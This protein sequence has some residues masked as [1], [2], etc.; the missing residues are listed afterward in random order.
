MATKRVCDHC[1]AEYFA[2]TGKLAGVV[3][4]RKEDEQ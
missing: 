4:L 2:D 3:I 1:G